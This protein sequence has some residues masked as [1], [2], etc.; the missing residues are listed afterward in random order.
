M[1]QEIKRLNQYPLPNGSKVL[2]VAI[3]SGQPIFASGLAAELPLS[4]ELVGCFDTIDSLEQGLPELRPDILVLE[5]MSTLSIEK[6][7]RLS[8]AAPQM[9][10]VLWIDSPST[11]FINHCIGVGVTAV[12]SRRAS[13]ANHKECLAAVARGENWMDQS[14]L[15]SLLSG[16]SIKLTPRERQLMTLIAQGLS[17]KEVAWRLTI[18][19]GTVKVYLSRLFAKAGVQNRFELALL[20]LRNMS[21]VASVP[22][23]SNPSAPVCMPPT[24][25][26]HSPTM[27]A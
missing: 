23:A 18:G 22:V 20:A 12:L 19:E 26:R 27:A 4:L 25:I 11:E 5:V 1:L 2:R 21:P 8:E 9:K 16:K 10:T 17:N 6:V 14:V 24:V 7:R 3:C 13:L 15:S